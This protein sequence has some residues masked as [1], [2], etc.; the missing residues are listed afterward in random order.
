M[1]ESSEEED[2]EYDEE[3]DFI[4]DDDAGDDYSSHIRQIFGYDKRKYAQ[5]YHE[6]SATILI[7][8]NPIAL[9]KA[10]IAY[11]FGLSECNRVNALRALHD[12]KEP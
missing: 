12:K 10:K 5:L 6:K 11:N 2:D 9:R 4:D 8:F 3:D 1:V 7:L